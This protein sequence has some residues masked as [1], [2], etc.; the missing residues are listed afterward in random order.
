MPGGGEMA[1]SVGTFTCVCGGT[2]MFTA[3]NKS[4]PA[5]SGVDQKG[6][7]ACLE[8]FWTS[9]VSSCAGC[10]GMVWLCMSPVPPCKA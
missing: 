4:S 10:V 7:V 3:L 6:M 2:V 9:R 1:M 5:D 8:S